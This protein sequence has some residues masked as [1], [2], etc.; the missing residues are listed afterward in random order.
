M[1]Y[2]NIGEAGRRRKVRD[3]ASET[4]PS[5]QALKLNGQQEILCALIG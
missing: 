3:V 1:G 2:V 5:L 4:V